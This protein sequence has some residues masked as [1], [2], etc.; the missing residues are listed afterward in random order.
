MRKGLALLALAVAGVIGL[1]YGLYAL[2]G[3]LQQRGGY[4]QEAVGSLYRMPE[5]PGRNL[6]ILAAFF[7]VLAFL[8]TPLV[9][10][11][12]ASERAYEREAARLRAQRPDDAVT[13]YAGVE[14]EGLSF[15]GP[16]GRILL[17]RGER[18]VGG[19]TVLK[20]R[21]SFDKHG[22]NP[23]RKALQ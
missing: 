20:L 5:S 21:P 16:E 1:G 7:V 11:E 9:L 15:A 17:L 4:L 8:L 12:R 22:D 13:P 18:G 2:V 19:P 6:M 3:A 10:A 23:L 14:G